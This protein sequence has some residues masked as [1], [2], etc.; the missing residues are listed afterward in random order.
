MADCHSDSR[1]HQLMAEDRCDFHWHQLFGSA[2]VGL[3]K[4]L[5]MPVL[6]ALIIPALAYVLLRRPLKVNPIAIRTC[7]G[8]GAPNRSDIDTMR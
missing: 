1:M 5:Q 4:D 3:V 8:M 7:A 2:Q 6:A